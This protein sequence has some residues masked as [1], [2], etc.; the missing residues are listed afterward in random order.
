MRNQAS[1]T[2]YSSAQRMNNLANEIAIFLGLPN[3]SLVNKTVLINYISDGK[4]NIIINGDWDNKVDFN[5]AL[6]NK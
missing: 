3:K 1:K 4:A 2:V 5:L 6:L